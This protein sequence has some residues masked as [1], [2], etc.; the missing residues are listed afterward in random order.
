MP[1]HVH[2]ILFFPTGQYGL[3][4]LVSNGKRFMAYEIV[5]RFMAYEIVKRLQQ[6]ELHHKLS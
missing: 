2:Y 4:K 1:N 5:K 3:N 6:L